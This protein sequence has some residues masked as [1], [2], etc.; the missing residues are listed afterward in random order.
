MIHIATTHFIKSKWI[1]PQVHW[2]DKN[3]T[4][5]H[6][7]WSIYDGSDDEFSGYSK[8]FH[9]FKSRESLKID[10]HK[11]SPMFSH[12][13]KLNKLFEL[14]SSDDDTTDDDVVIFLD[15]D[16]WPI[17][18]LDEFILNNISRYPLSA[19]QR[20]ED[21]GWDLQ[22]HPS[23]CMTTVGFFK[24]IKRGWFPGYHWYNCDM[25]MCRT[26]VGGE[27]LY[28]LIKNDIDWKRIRRSNKVNYDKLNYGI[29]GDI[30]YHHTSASHD[31]HRSKT[32]KRAKPDDVDSI[33]AKVDE[34]EDDIFSL[35]E[36]FWDRFI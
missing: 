3:I 17:A 20:F 30:I 27:L 13:S 9:F 8:Y 12:S 6:K 23:F 22:P 24:N 33:M 16:A 32:I 5:P 14:I 29:Y 7:I 34:L 11:N 4:L 26:D 10:E 18:N 2:I 15:S 31:I 19:I 35:K 21:N 1:I 36:N 25:K 28:Y